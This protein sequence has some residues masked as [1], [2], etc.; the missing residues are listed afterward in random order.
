MIKDTSR[1]I[2]DALYKLS[3][4]MHDVRPKDILPNVSYELEV[5]QQVPLLCKIS[6]VDMKPPLTVFILYK[7]E[8]KDLTLFH[9]FKNPDPNEEDWAGVNKNLNKVLIVENSKYHFDSRQIF[10]S[11]NSTIGCDIRIIARFKKTERFNLSSIITPKQDGETV[12]DIYDAKIVEN[13]V[14]QIQDVKQTI[15]QG[16]LTMISFHIFVTF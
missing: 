4:A 15:Y 8:I 5:T 12:E 3:K 14:N 2:K 1:E 9:S 10:L 16:K 7:S 11:F 13:M 6:L